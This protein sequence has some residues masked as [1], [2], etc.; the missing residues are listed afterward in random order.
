MLLT[1]RESRMVRTS[2]S[3]SRRKPLCRPRAQFAHRD[4]VF[5]HAPS[6]R[7]H[8]SSATV[9]LLINSDAQIDAF[10]IICTITSC[11]GPPTPPP[12]ALKQTVPREL[13]GSIASLL[14]DPLVRAFPLSS[15]KRICLLAMKVLRRGICFPVE[16]GMGSVPCEADLRGLEAPAAGRVLQHE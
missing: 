6:V 8:G 13:M 14:D 15:R 2:Q 5:Y 1:D 11:G 3:R 12:T 10:V 4:S 16:L 7:N 9:S